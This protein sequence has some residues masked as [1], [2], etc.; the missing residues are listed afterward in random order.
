M[1]S[2]EKCCSEDASLIPILYGLF[3]FLAFLFPVAV[4]FLVLA[5]LNCRRHP[6]MIG[7]AWDFVGALF[8]VSGFLLVGGPWILTGL[9]AQWRNSLMQGRAGALTAQSS[10]W[11][12]FWI[13]IWTIYFLLVVVGVA[14]LLWRRRRVTVIYNAEPALIEEALARTLD[15]L[16]LEGALV[17]NRLFIGLHS[18]TEAGK[19]GP[20]PEA[21]PARAPLT[22]FQPADAGG[23]DTG[24]GQPEHPTDGP[25]PA[26]HY[27]DL[28]R[29]AVVE[30]DPFPATHNMTLRWRAGESDDPTLRRDVE[31]E[32]AKVLREA[33]SSPNPATAWFLTVSSCLFLLMLI[34]LALLIF[35]ESK[36]S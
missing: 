25:G 32:L 6:T 28:R 18:A 19:P 15:R 24:R 21:V 22:S 12:S 33:E 36:R 14:V 27:L 9:N 1:G 20:R 10:E 35:L 17:G 13:M 16:G 29:T 26:T 7:G 3:G 31:A 11:W 5:V 30:L 8:A 4:Y 23:Q 34:G 2:F